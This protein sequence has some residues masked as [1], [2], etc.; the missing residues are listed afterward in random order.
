M[1]QKSKEKKI[2][3]ENFRI[4]LSYCWSDREASH[5]LADKFIKEKF[6]I[7]IDRD[8]TSSED[9]FIAMDNSDLAVLLIS[10]SYFN[11]S[12]C[13]KEAKYAFDR[14]MNI[15]IVN[16]NQGFVP[17]KWIAQVIGGKKYSLLIDSSNYFSS[18]HFE[19]I[20]EKIV[21]LESILNIEQDL[22][23]SL[24]RSII[25]YSSCLMKTY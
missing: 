16:L 6:K 4:L 14:N 17:D 22:T 20:K 7:W 18:A 24:N 9:L 21:S 11:C 5:A 2:N 10:K 19:R 1:K 15:L 23:Y 3:Y 12:D 8:R 25:V 13:Q